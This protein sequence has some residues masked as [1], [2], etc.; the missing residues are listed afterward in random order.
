MDTLR[1]A[2]VSFGFLGYSPLAPGTFG[3]LGPALLA[4][5]LPRE[6][7]FAWVSLGGIVVLLIVSVWLGPWA[8]KEYGRKDP[9][10]FVLDEVGGYLVTVCAAHPPTWTVSFLA[11]F[12]F[13]IAD[14]VKPWPAARVERLPGGWGIYLDDILAALWSLLALRGL[15]HWFPG[16]AA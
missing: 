9:G 14:I 5:L 4:P 7:P 3:T 15:I 12:L 16:L 10:P 13:R 8:E 11:F 2:I 6:T 1:R